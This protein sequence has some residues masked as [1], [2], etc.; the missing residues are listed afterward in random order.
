MLTVQLGQTVRHR[1]LFTALVNPSPRYSHA[2]K[3][4]MDSSSLSTRGRVTALATFVFVSSGFQSQERKMVWSLGEAS[5][6]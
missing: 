5:I 3:P 4:Q 6:P 2:T 1:S